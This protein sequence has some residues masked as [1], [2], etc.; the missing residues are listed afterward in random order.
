MESYC[1][2]CGAPI[3]EN[4]KVCGN[5]G[6]P[7]AQAPQ[8][9]QAAYNPYQQ[10]ADMQQKKPANNKIIVIA[11]AAV[12]AVIAIIAII[13]GVA[14]SGY[15]KPVKALAQSFEDADFDMLVDCVEKEKV[16]DF[17]NK[18]E[19]ELFFD[20]I[21]DYIEDEC[22]KGY[23]VKVEYNDKEKLNKDDIEEFVEDMEDEENIEYDEDDMTK[24]YVV[25]VTFTAEGDDGDVVILDGDIYV[26]KYDG[27]WIIVELD[28]NFECEDD[29]SEYAEKNASKYASRYYELYY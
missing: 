18:K 28:M 29:V 12:V 5:C 16:D 23:E 17:G 13:A 19:M 10:P 14:G 9:P 6:T 20:I 7:V 15:K 3:Q 21:Y 24:L 26:A 11:A 27:E 22:G 2:N 25:D 8:M 4:Y 1:G